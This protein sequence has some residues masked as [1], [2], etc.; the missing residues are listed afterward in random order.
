MLFTREKFENCDAAIWENKV[1]FCNWYL[2]ANFH[3]KDF[4]TENTKFNDKSFPK[5]KLE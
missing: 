1:E 2:A 5:K 3:S 4:Q